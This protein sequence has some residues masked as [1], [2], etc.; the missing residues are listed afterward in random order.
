MKEK[1]CEREKEKH[2][3]ENVV[4]RE[5]ES[6]SESER[7]RAMLTRILFLKMHFLQLVQLDRCSFRPLS[8]AKV[9]SGPVTSLTHHG[10]AFVA[11][12]SVRGIVR[13]WDRETMTQT[14]TIHCHR[15]FIIL[16]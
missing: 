12:A 2:V 13:I 11:T 15:Y 16:L 1:L 4:V 6:E 9:H 3:K 5:S 10:D 7:E 8:S 14:A